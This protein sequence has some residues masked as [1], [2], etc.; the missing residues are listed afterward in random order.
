M[1][2][3]DRVKHPKLGEGIICSIGKYGCLINFSNKDGVL[4][5]GSKFEDLELIEDV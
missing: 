3:G 2:V 1:K 5:R 4:V